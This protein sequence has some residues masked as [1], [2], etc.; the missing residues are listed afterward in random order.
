MFIFLVPKLAFSFCA[1]WSSSYALRE[2]HLAAARAKAK[3][4]SHLA[5]ETLQLLSYCKTRS[6]KDITAAFPS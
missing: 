3:G 1:G 5:T 6:A 2:R 4:F